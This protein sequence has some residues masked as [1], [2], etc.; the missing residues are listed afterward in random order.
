[1]PKS[2]EE[3]VFYIFFKKPALWTHNKMQLH[4][5]E[6]QLR[7][8]VLN[9]ENCHCAAGDGTAWCSVIQTKTTSFEQLSIEKATHNMAVRK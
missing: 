5:K 1:M 6:N 8:S 3:L 9:F 2:V 4:I 7:T